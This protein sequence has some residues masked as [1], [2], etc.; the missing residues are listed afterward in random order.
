MIPPDY[1]DFESFDSI[2]EL[3]ARAYNCLTN[4]RGGIFR[5][6]P[7]TTIGEFR[8]LMTI[9]S[10]SDLLTVKHLGVKTLAEIRE[11]HRRLEQRAE[12]V[13]PSRAWE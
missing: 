5:F 6:K 13:F 11:L 8:A 4:P 2:A 3:S 12:F 9:A 10:D 1:P 7:I